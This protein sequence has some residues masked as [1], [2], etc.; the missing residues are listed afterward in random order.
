MRCA[1]NGASGCGSPGAR[2]V[3]AVGDVVVGG[4]EVGHVEQVAQRQ[5]P[6]GAQAALD[7]VVLG[8]RRSAA[9][10]AASLVPTSS[11]TPWFLQ[12]QPELLAVV[13]AEQVRAGQR[14]LVGAGPGDEAVAQARV[15]A[16][17]RCRCAR[18]R[19]GSRRARAAGERRRRRRSAAGASRRCAMLRVVDRAH[20]RRA[21]RP[22]RRSGQARRSSERG[23]CG[24][25]GC[26]PYSSRLRPVHAAAC[27]RLHC[28]APRH[29]RSDW[30][31]HR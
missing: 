20:L 18:A 15:G 14:G 26:K 25:L 2:L 22:G 17:H 27:G 6:V 31:A 8:E 30:R 29:A 24:S 3:R 28:R 13:V 10:S 23:A 12:Q 16:R 11:G 19:T 9:G 4:V 5:A 1:V 7:M 21:R